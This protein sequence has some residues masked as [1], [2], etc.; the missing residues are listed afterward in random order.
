M[1]SVTAA[2]RPPRALPLVV[3]PANKHSM[4]LAMF[5]SAAAVYLIGNHFHIF[6]PQYLQR[7]WI[8]FAVPFMP[9]TVWIYL[10]EYAF[11]PAVYLLCRNYINL[12]KYFYSFIALQL[13]SVLIFFV[14]PTTYPRAEFPLTAD[15]NAITYFAFSSLRQTDTPAS[16]CPSLHVSSVYLSVFLFREE[17]R[18]LL[19][20]FFI[21][22]TAIA[23]T[24]LTTKQHYLID[25]ITGFLMAVLFHWIFHS[26]INYRPLDGD[27]AKR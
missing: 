21:W 26:L 3:H 4:G 11:F 19:L 17:R 18:N 22:G 16:C 2:V 10:S 12:N 20:P 25:V 23:A 27:Q 1:T 6:P 24:T 7:T 13:T 15:I 9:N 8:D 14:W 5:L